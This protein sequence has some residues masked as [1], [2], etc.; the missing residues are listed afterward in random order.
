MK[1]LGENSI[2]EFLQ[3]RMDKK[4]NSVNFQ[5]I[6][7]KIIAF[8]K[9]CY[10]FNVIFIFIYYYINDQIYKFAITLQRI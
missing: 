4:N 1:I 2:Y 3:M 8:A 7:I 6:I 10:L 5:I 9:K